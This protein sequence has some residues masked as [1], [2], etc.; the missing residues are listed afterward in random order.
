MEQESLKRGIELTNRLGQEW[1]GDRLGIT[2]LWWKSGKINKATFL[3]LGVVFFVNLFLVFPL[4][5]RDTSSS[6]SSSTV[7]SFFGNLFE[8]TG[9]F[10][11]VYLFQILTFI[12]LSFAPVSFYLFVRKTALGHEPT[13]FLA[14]IL[15]V[16]P[17]PFLGGGLPFARA[18]LSGDG[19]HAFAF[20]FVP[21]LLLSVE[22][23][24]AMGAPFWRV[25]SSIGT[26]ITAIISPFVAFNLL[27]FIF[28]ITVAEGFM[29]NL[30]VKF[31]RLLVLLIASFGLSL[32][33]YY[34]SVSLE[35][36]DISHVLF[37]INKFW[38]IFPILI[39]IVPIAGIIFFLI[40]DRRAKLKPIFI[41]FAFL[42]V[43][44]FLYS[45][46]KNLAVSGIFTADRY[47]IEL[48]FAR[49]LFVSLGFVLIAEFII[50][51]YVLN[52][53]KIVLFLLSTIATI[54]LLVLIVL[55]MQSTLTLRS[56]FAD[57]EIFNPYSF[58]IGSIKR[59]GLKFPDIVATTLSI[60]TFVFLIFMFKKDTKVSA[61]IKEKE[62]LAK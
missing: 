10:P 14:T 20:T 7:F 8:G 54:A 44:I 19:A 49:S 5:M 57:Q 6:Y 13:A 2:F 60:I 59:S 51:N 45:T 11:K 32:F 35:I 27:I 34:P 22:A 53:S 41:S 52:K 21:L 33:W 50:R 46:S 38:S 55:V 15:Y 39:P 36:L 1:F 25:V 42:A 24:I 62:D 37:A 58:G 12:S 17:I 43:Y 29:G 30:R 4:F 31:S 23:F 16:L 18:I 61:I 56:N 3:F 28:I 40:L 26:A 9:L 47:L 48:S